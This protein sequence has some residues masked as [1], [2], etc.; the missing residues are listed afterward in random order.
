MKLRNPLWQ[1]LLR[2]LGA[3]TTGLALAAGLL[4]LPSPAAAQTVVKL[5]SLVPTGSLWHRTLEEQGAEWKR[6]TGGRVTVRLYPGGVAGDDPDMVR[7]MRI[8]QFQAAALTAQGLVEI[9]NAFSIFQIPMFYASTE[10][11]FYVLDR[12][13]PLLKQRLEAKGFVLLNWGYAGQV[14]PY[15]KRPIRS[16]ADLQSQKLFLWG[17][18]DRAVR[19]WRAHGLQPVA[20]AATDILMGLQTGM[21]DAF[22]TTPLAALSLQWYRT[23]PYQ[24]DEALSP[25]MGAT[26]M[27]RKTWNALSEQDRAAILAIAGRADVR[28]R[29]EVPLQEQRAVAEMKARGLTVTSIPPAQRPAWDKMAQSFTTA[30]RGQVVP[31]DLYDQARQARDQFRKTRTASGPR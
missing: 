11:F 27:T 13:T 22:T 1:H 8:G 6:A 23:A 30:Y 15:S 24:L 20:G 25:L 2:A 29:K 18:E 31:A 5:V 7:K 28:F 4:A 16:L 9:D 26:V 10:E 12:L 17:D 19:V 21:F 14:H 3:T